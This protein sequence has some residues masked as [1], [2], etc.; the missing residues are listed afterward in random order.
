MHSISAPSRGLY[1][2]KE[3][4]QVLGLLLEIYFKL[5]DQGYTF[6]SSSL[7]NKT[8]HI[9][10]WMPPCFFTYYKCSDWNPYMCFDDVCKSYTIYRCFLWYQVS[11]S[12]PKLHTHIIEYKS[13]TI[14]LPVIHVSHL[15]QGSQLNRTTLTRESICNIHGCIEIVFPP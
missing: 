8:I 10:R 15:F 9:D 6:V 11:Y 3:L 2:K 12:H 7:T 1:S 13:V 4:C 14:Q 5:V